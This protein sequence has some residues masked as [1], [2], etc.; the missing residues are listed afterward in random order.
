MMNSFNLTLSGKHFICLS[1]LDDS[2]AEESNQGCRSLPFMSLNTSFQPLP[3]C[4]VSFEKSADS[5]MGTPLEV[6]VSFS[7]AALKILSLPFILGDVIVMCL[8]VCFRGSNF[9]GTLSF[10]DFLEVLI[11]CHIWEVLLLHFFN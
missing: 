2:F 6:T 10:L 4:K 9:F 1:I 5:L 3:A 11:L 7:L 8:G